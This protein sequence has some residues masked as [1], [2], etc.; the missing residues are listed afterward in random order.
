M[1]VAEDVL[2]KVRAGMRGLQAPGHF[3]KVYKNECMYSFDT[4]ESPGGLYVNL[5]TW[6]V[7]EQQGRGE[8]GASLKF[9]IAGSLSADLSLSYLTTADQGM[10]CCRG[11]Q[12]HLCHVCSLCCALINTLWIACGAAAVL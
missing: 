2:D 5:K 1:A 10:H 7:C 3:D 8:A 12:L 11:Q 9:G 4:P 6:Q